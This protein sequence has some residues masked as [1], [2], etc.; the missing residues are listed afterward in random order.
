MEEADLSKVYQNPKRNWEE[1]RIEF[2]GSSH[3]S[4]IIELFFEK[5]IAT[6]S[7]YFNAYRIMVA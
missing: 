6:H 7:L 2:L 5:E 4:E 1:F 3:F